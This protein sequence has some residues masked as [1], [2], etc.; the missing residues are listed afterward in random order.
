MGD[1]CSQNREFSRLL[2]NSILLSGW[3]TRKHNGDMRK[4]AKSG[5]KSNLIPLLEYGCIEL[6]VY[7]LAR[8]IAQLI[9]DICH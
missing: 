8:E 4:L 1:S 3:R 5:V 6:K 9:K 2:K 7:P